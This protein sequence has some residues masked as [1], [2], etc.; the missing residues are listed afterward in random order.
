[1]S[2]PAA[3]TRLDQPVV[4]GVVGLGYVGL[5]LACAFARTVPCI[6]FDISRER[7][8]QLRDGFDRTRETLASDLRAPLLRL[9]DDPAAL[10][11]A[12]V[13]IVAVPTPVDS[14]KKPDLGALGLACETVGRHMARGTLVVFESTVY[15]GV[16]EEFCVPALERASR[17]AFGSDFT[18]GYSPERINPGDSEHTI[19]KVVKVVAGCTPDVTARMAQ[20]Y[21][22]VVKAGIHCAPTIKTA[23]AAKV[24]ENTQRDLNIALMNEL[25]II[26]DR[27]GISTKAVLEAAA[28]KW[29]F[30]PFRPGLVG[31][32][33]IGVDPYYLTYKAEELGYH[34]QVIL[35]GRRIN[36]SMGMYVAQQ[37][38]KAMIRAGKVIDNAT[39]L[40]LGVAFKPNVP[41][42]RNTRVA[43]VVTELRSYGIAVDV[44]DP[45]VDPEEAKRELNVTLVADPFA[46][47][48]AYDA[49]IL[50][51]G[52]DAFKARPAEELVGLLREGRGRGV[53]V[54]VGGVITRDAA[55][56]L[57]VSY[58]SL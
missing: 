36:D 45:L 55:E 39:V 47:R 52:H 32:H 8:E 6:G 12:N 40:V 24:I 15:P 41:D 50:A 30:L 34:S 58:W 9:T 1:M 13:I 7:I 29:N 48:R 4:I 25:A 54:D 18:V 26:F 37:T 46:R 20:V 43:D 3:N 2:A 42:M 51:V 35:S 10:H 53:L 57:G 56:A 49:V 5:P 31:G 16:T 11:D 14:H 33:C 23:E 38:V 44:S 21:G 27:A 28:T 22:L 17:L 19:D